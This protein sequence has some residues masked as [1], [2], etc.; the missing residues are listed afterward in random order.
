MAYQ[1][2]IAPYVDMLKRRKY[3]LI[4]PV[5]ASLI[6]GSAVAYKLPAVYRSEAKIFYYSPQIPETM[7]ASLVNTFLET[8]I[9]YMEAFIFS[10]DRCLQIINEVNLYPDM[11]QKMPT[12][13]VIANM[14]EQYTSA[15]LYESVGTSKRSGGEEVIIGFKFSFDDRD[16]KKAFNVATII[17]SD[18]I[19]NYK[20]FREGFATVSSTFFYDEQQRLKEEMAKLDKKLSEFKEKHLNELPELFQHNYQMV[21]TLNQQLLAQDQ[22]A[23]FIVEKKIMLESYLATTDPFL[24]MEGISGQKI[25]TPDEKLGSLKVELALLLSSVSEKHPDVIRV[26]REIESLEKIVPKDRKDTDSQTEVKNQENYWVKRLKFKE[27]AAAYNPVYVNLVTQ[28]E[29]TSA[30]MKSLQTQKDKIKAEME[31]YKLRLEKSPVIE[32]EYALLFRDMESNKRR[33]GELVNQALQTDSSS[34]MEKREIGGRLVIVEPPNFP[35]RPIKPNRPLIVAIGFVV[36]TGLGILLIITW[37]FLYQTVRSPDD[38]SKITPFSV[39][40]E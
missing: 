25:I 7:L 10:R 28:L 3:F 4:I 19:A 11:I 8:A 39:L 27:Q 31:K 9:K 34:A 33:Y 38:L 17:A 2:D 14:K 5:I 37:E 20:K 29:E 40:S 32:Q 13:D 23:R 26:K 1:T 16:P 6:I 22:E 18:F 35:L 21:Q 30:Q 12:D 36:V 24:Q 15:N